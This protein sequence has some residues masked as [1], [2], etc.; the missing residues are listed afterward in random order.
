VDF[1]ISLKA[2]R[3]SFFCRIFVGVPAGKLQ[4]CA[5]RVQA[6]ENAA[7]KKAGSVASGLLPLVAPVNE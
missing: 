4:C 3:L 7:K 2:A 6:Y 5:L 1:E